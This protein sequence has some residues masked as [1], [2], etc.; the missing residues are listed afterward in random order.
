[1]SKNKGKSEDVVY[2]LVKPNTGGSMPDRKYPLSKAI[3]SED[4][5]MVEGEERKIAY[6]LGESSC[7][8]EEWRQNDPKLGPP[9]TFE[10]GMITVP[11]RNKCLIQ[12]L[13]LNNRSSDND[14]KIGNTFTVYKRLN[15][16]KDVKDAMREQ[17]RKKLAL[18][19]YWEIQADQDKSRAVARKLGLYGDGKLHQMKVLSYAENNY[20]D[21]LEFTGNVQDMESAV[22]LD[23]IHQANEEG[24]IVYN[25]GRWYWKK[26]DDVI[27]AIPKGMDRHEYLTGWTF[28]SAEG[29]IF[30]K[31]LRSL[32]VKD[33][34]EFVTNEVV[35]SKSEQQEV[36]ALDTD[37]LVDGC[38]KYK[39][40]VYNTSVR[41]FQFDNG[42]KVVDLGK[43]KAL[44]A[45]YM[46]DED[47]STVTDDIKARFMLAQ[48]AV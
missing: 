34:G 25:Q 19:A 7:F 37:T 2:V 3:S 11:A 20:E 12:F 33:N 16:Q 38:K 17:K 8:P 6:V 10:K 48:K 42:S 43:S 26:G 27:V 14:D 9:P 4:F 1:M 35:I 24:H 18:D 32:V 40:I 15:I 47:N 22:R 41:E 5:V 39:I 45:E 46:E 44:V 29:K 23:I 31:S 13:D 28:G 21:F 36:D 30:Y